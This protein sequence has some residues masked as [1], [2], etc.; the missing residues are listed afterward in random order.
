LLRLRLFGWKVLFTHRL[1]ERRGQTDPGGAL[2]LVR[3]RGATDDA[4]YGDVRTDSN[5]P[6]ERSVGVFVRSCSCLPRRLHRAVG[7]ARALPASPEL[8]VFSG[9]WRPLLG[10]HRDC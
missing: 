10:F 6:P 9:W 4:V 7:T 5:P 1:L 3:S 2:T 8:P